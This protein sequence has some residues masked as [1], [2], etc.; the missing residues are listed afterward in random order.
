MS[1]ESKLV[2]FRAHVACFRGGDHAS[3]FYRDATERAATLIPFLQIGL[4]VNERCVCIVAGKEMSSLRGALQTAG[5]DVE[6]AVKRDALRLLTPEESYLHGGT[7]DAN[8]M[9]N[10]V[11]SAIRGAIAHGFSGFRIAG[12]MGWAAEEPSVQDQ[13]DRYEELVAAA[14]P[15]HPVRALCMYDRRRF[16]T[17]ALERIMRSH[18]LAVTHPDPSTCA[19]RLREGVNFGDVFFDAHK[20][21]VFHY[22]IQQD[23]TPESLTTG[24]AARLSS[25]L[26]AVEDGFHSL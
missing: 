10:S 4:R 17:L 18:R 14:F 11:R 19:V 25:A 20:P 16:G 1:E 15:G 3:L 24:K 6:A 9:A 26:R 21:S 2:P 5:V 7:F 23:G 8:R 13:L 12:D 22:T